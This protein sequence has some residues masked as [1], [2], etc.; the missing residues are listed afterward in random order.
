MQILSIIFLSVYVLCILLISLYCLVQFSLLLHYNQFYKKK[1]SELS[2]EAIN[3]RD[4]PIVTVQ[5]PVYNE[6]FV[7]ERLIDQV[8]LFNYPQEKLQIQVLDDSTDETLLISQ[9]K[10]EYYKNIGFD[11]SLI[12]RTDRTGYKAGALKNAMPDSKGE[13]IAIFDA[14]FLPGPDFLMQCLLYFTDK[15]IGVVQ[16]R[17]DHINQSYN[18]LTELQAVQLNV[19][20]TIEQTGRMEGGHLLQFNGTAGIW[21]KKAI[22]DAGGWHI[23]TLTEDLDLSIRSQLKGWKIKYLEEIGIPSELPV[24]M[25]GLKSQQFRW[26]KGGAECAKKLLPKVWKSD[27]SFNKKIYS[28]FHL[29]SSSI[30]ILIFLSGVLTVPVMLFYKYYDY[31]LRWLGFFLLSWILIFIV[32][33]KANFNQNVRSHYSLREAIAFLV[34]FPV[35]LSMSMGLSLH[36]SIAVREGFMGRKSAFI[37]TPKFNILSKTDTLASNNYLISK[38]PLSTKLEFLMAFFYLS[39]ILFGILTHNYVYLFVHIMF[40]A[41]FLSISVLSWKHLKN[42]P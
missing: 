18:L 34:R 33:F 24:E 4:L 7:V 35:F 37:R 42:Q 27:L 2:P 31:N 5:L 19:H 15:K 29:L 40:F 13:F 28:T 41:G 3:Y 17:W 6:Q 22:E 11:I 12:H 26:M 1:K 14:D 39:C 10:V 32:Y 23:D 20:F 8:M 36:N 21:R 25:N 16:T 30:F 38:M 9:R